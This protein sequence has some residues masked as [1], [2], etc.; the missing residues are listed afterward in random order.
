MSWATD[1]PVRCARAPQGCTA[2]FPGSKNHAIRA[3]AEGWFFSKAGDGTN[4]VAYCPEHVPDW[5]PAW[6]AAR[7]AAAEGETS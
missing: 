1:H 4:P 7:Q 3:G 2:S 6:R 5:V